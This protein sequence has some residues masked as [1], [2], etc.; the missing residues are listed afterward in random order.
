MRKILIVFL[1][2]VS[3]IL[4]AQNIYIDCEFD[5]IAGYE[6]TDNIDNDYSY[7]I[8]KN[9]RFIEFIFENDQLIKYETV[10]RI[11]KINNDKAID[12]YNKFSISL[13]DVFDITNIKA[14]TIRKNGEVIE[15]DESNIKEVENLDEEG[16]YKKFAID[17]VEIGSIIEINYRLKKYPRLY[18]S[19][20]FQSE[21]VTYNTLFQVISPKHLEFDAKSYNKELVKT[22]TV[23]DEKRYLT[24]SCDSIDPIDVNESYSFPSANKVR[25]EYSYRMNNEYH[26]SPYYTYSLAAQNIYGLLYNIENKEEKIIQKLIQKIQLNNLSYEEKIFKIEKYLKENFIIRPI[27][28]INDGVAIS[29]IVKNGYSSE[30]G[31]TKLFVNVF[32]FAGIEHNI[33]ATSDKTNKKFDKDFMTWNYVND[34]LIYFPKSNK[35]LT[36]TLIEYRYPAIPTEFYFNEG[37]FLKLIEIG[38][39]E[40][41]VH[42]IKEI[43]DHSYTQSFINH[44]ITAKFS[45]NLDLINTN[46]THSFGGNSAYTIKQYYAF[47]PEEQRNLMINE[48]IKDINDDVEVIDYT[49]E[50]G[51]INVNPFEKPFNIVTNLNIHSIIE[52]A[53]NSYL[54]KIGELIGRQ[55]E[56]YQEH[57]RQQKIDFNYPHI[58]DREIVIKI[59]DGYKVVGMEKLKIDLQK[60]NSDNNEDYTMGFISDYEISDNVLKVNI[61]EYYTTATYPIEQYEDFR[62]VVNAAAD[63]TK[64]VLVLK[65]E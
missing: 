20:Y 22:D 21:G 33:V 14:R 32:K 16:N 35:L 18:G 52:N 57:E 6:S 19:Y 2:S 59:P 63:F 62:K 29:S 17:G 26:T 58:L 48:Y 37:I 27:E 45:E 7:E 36:P 39:I 9:E 10:K 54:F 38:G 8:L 41:A 51:D 23:I 12:I 40:N 28:N 47:L 15:F 65:S 13:F 34:Y 1:I 61:H 3:T 24:L 42:K 55:V 56:L 46:I 43:P 49:V 64:V 50:N 25:V 4:T 5:N 44:K 30:T 53:G 31:I 11:I 60:G